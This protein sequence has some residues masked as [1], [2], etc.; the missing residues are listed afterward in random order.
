MFCEVGVRKSLL[1]KWKK[2]SGKTTT[3]SFPKCPTI[4]TFTSWNKPSSQQERHSPEA[5]H[6]YWEKIQNQK[7]HWRGCSRCKQQRRNIK[8]STEIYFHTTAVIT[9]P[10]PP[11]LKLITQHDSSGQME[12]S[13]HVRNS[14]ALQQWLRIIILLDAWETTACNTCPQHCV[15]SILEEKTAWKAQD[16]WHRRTPLAHRHQCR[17]C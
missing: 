16:K 17:Y 5:P 4:P 13:G 1:S 12:S 7:L 6:I 2:A 14:F 9:K 8:C 15:I 11:V 3:S 10:A